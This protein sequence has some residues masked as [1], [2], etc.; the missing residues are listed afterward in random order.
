MSDLM[1]RPFY[2]L[3]LFIPTLLPGLAAQCLSGDCTNGYGVYRYPSGARYEGNFRNGEIDGTGTCYYTDGSVYSGQWV[4]RYPEGKGTK[5]YPDGTQRSGLWKKGQPVDE[6][7]R[8]IPAAVVSQWEKKNDGTDVQSGCITGNCRNG[9]G[10][11]AFPDGSKYEGQF[12]NGRIDGWGTWFYPNGDKYVGTFRNNYAHGKGTLYRTDS[13]RVSGDWVEGEFRGNSVIEKGRTGCIEGNCHQ[14]SGTYIYRDGTAKYTGQF[15]NDLPHGE[16]AIFYANQ[17]RYVGQW[18]EGV[19]SG[20]GTLYRLDGTEVTGYWEKGVFLGRSLPEPLDKTDDHSSPALSDHAASARV[21]NPRIPEADIP[22]P[23]SESTE[24]PATV[25]PSDSTALVAVSPDRDSPQDSPAAAPDSG[26][27][28]SDDHLPQEEAAAV[29]ESK[30]EIFKPAF[31]VWAVVVGVAAYNHMP[32]LRYTDDDAYRIYAFLKSPEGGGLPDDQIQ[33]LVDEDATRQLILNAMETTF[34]KAGPN[35]LIVLYYSGHGLQGSFLPYDYDGFNNK[36]LHEDINDIF[37]RSAAKYKLC[38]A[39]ACHSGS[40]LALKGASTESALAVYYQT[41][42]QAAAGTALIMS[43]KSEETSLESTGLRQGVFSHFLIRGLKGEA[44][45]DGNQVVGV[46]ELFDYIYEG[47]RDYTGNRQSPVIKG[48]Y[49][50]A[51]TVAVIRQ[52]SP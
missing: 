20:K 13:T 18:K 14:G 25:S 31:K 9:E 10:V 48:S 3:L 41:L 45:F 21:S 2:F 24:L 30:I 38:I 34:M 37:E 29:S 32:A 47:V 28:V 11:F 17:E 40:L 16:G 7:G 1:T 22:D 42:G 15:V 19:F 51:M 46:Q 39:D 49:D 36:L 23:L 5:T 4:A 52:H 33:V 6:N 27:A 43:S 12:L 35:D 50:P 8:P 26:I 44:D